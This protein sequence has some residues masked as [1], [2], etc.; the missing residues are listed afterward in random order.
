MPR[1]QVA[2]AGV[3]RSRTF[4][5]EKVE[6]VVDV[7]GTALQ[8]VTYDPARRGLFPAGARVQVACD[9]SFVRSLP[10]DPR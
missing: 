7:Q 3:V 4:L 8:A 9:P 1:G 2:A 6:Y 10:D 5:G